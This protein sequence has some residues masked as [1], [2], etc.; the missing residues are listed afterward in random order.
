MLAIDIET[1][2]PNLSDMGSGCIRKDGFIL[3]VGTYDGKNAT[4]Y[5]PNISRD[6]AILKDILARDEDKIFHNGIYDTQWL[7][8]GYGFTI[9][10]TIHDTMTRA[11]F[12]DEYAPLDLDSCCKRMRI[13]GKNKDDTIEKWYSEHRK[14]LGFKELN[15]W[16]VVDKLMEYP[17]FTNALYEYNKQDC[18]ATY[19]LYLA[20]EPYMKPYSDAYRMECDLY[21]LLWHM[22]HNGVRIDLEGLKRLTDEIHSNIEQDIITLKDKWNL[23]PEV[24]R[25][26]KKMTIAMHNLGIR[27][28]LLTATGAESWAAGALDKIN[29]PIVKDIFQYKIDEA[30]LNK[31]LEGSMARCIINGRIHADFSPNKRD[32]QA[33]QAGGAI[34]GRFASAAPNLQNISAR[35]FKHGCKTYGEELRQLFLPEENCYL[36]ACDYSQIEYVLFMHY[37]QGSLAAKMKQAIMDGVDFHNLAMDIT[38]ISARSCVKSINYG[39]L[40]GMGF[41]T[42]LNGPNYQTWKSEGEKVGMTAEEYCQ[43]CFTTYDEKL[44][45]IAQTIGL[46]QNEARTFGYVTSLSGRRHHNPKPVF[47]NGRWN[48]GLYKQTNYKIQGGGADILKQ[49]LLLAWKD[50]V[51]NTLKMHLTVHDENVCSVPKSKEGVEAAAYLEE[52]MDKAYYDI[53]T[54]PIRAEGGIGENWG[55]KHSEGAWQDLRK[56]YGL[57]SS[58]EMQQ[59]LWSVHH[60]G[61]IN[62]LHEAAKGNKETKENMK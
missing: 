53:L 20:Q 59:R 57:E 18:I 13:Q 17:E 2:D 21:P 28:P 54:V 9:N 5:N 3:C 60:T 45:V 26:P 31:Y 44:P 4:V 36:F 19:N 39:K 25:S 1:Y 56:A 23:E 34:T 29:H 8:E 47:E 24:L 41:N 42:M 12:I 32:S 62:T 16:K 43:H 58:S 48:N 52:C 11:V 38:G 37:A 14:D 35:E 30:L 6:R 50:G 51:F 40:Y 10:G 46:I 33:G 22:K 55:A 61:I 49:G 27:S 15:L 7:I